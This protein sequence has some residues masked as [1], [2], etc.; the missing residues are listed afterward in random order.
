MKKLF[1]ILILI[2]IGIQFIPYGKEHINSSILSE[3]KWDTPQTKALFMRACGDC[4]SN[5]TKWPW[6]SNIAPISWVVYN[7]VEDGR[8]K[9]NVSMWEHQDNEAK[10]AIKEI[11]EKKMPLSSYI[12]VHP[13]ANLTDE[14]NQQLIQGLKIT[15]GIDKE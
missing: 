15:F 10:D 12:L 4:H 11:K 13:E 8:E 6:Y 9:L 14:E 5:E 7:H 1:L 2:L 3:P